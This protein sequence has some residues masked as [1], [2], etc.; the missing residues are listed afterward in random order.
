MNQRM[1]R[2][3]LV[4]LLAGGIG[5]RLVHLIPALKRMIDTN[6]TSVAR[7]DWTLSVGTTDHH[8]ACGAA[9]VGM[10]RAA[11]GLMSA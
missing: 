7:K 10:K 6:L 5:I 11:E 8:A 2:I 4:V 3:S 1:L 9:R